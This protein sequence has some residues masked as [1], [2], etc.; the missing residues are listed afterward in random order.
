MEPQDEPGFSIR[1]YTERYAPNHEV[2]L[3]TDIGGWDYDIY[4]DYSRTSDGRGFWLFTLDPSRYFPVAGS[5][6]QVSLVVDRSYRMEHEPLRFPS[7]GDHHI[8]EDEVKFGEVPDRFLHGHDNLHVFETPVQQH[9]FRANH[10][11]DVVYDAIVV[12]SGMSGGIIADELSDRG[13]NVLLLE[14]GSLLF[15]THIYNLP[16]DWDPLKD[17]YF[18][19]GH[20]TSTDSTFEGGVK[21]NLGGGSLFWSGIIQQAEPWEFGGHWP[22]A[23]QDY[24][25]T[26][27]G[28]DRALSLMRRQLTR[29]PYEEQLV[30]EV[31]TQFPEYKV[32]RLP[33]AR[34]QPHL[35]ELRDGR[36]IQQNLIRESNGLFSTVDLLLDSMAFPGSAG[37]ANLTINTNHMV[38]H[39]EAEGGHVNAVICED[40]LANKRRRFKG[41]FVILAAGSLGSTR[42]ALASQ[43][44]DPNH[45]IGKGLTDHPN[46]S[47]R[48][49]WP[50]EDAPLGTQDHAKLMIQHAD[51]ADQNHPYNI[52]VM[53]NYQ[54][55]DRRVA[56]EDLWQQVIVQAMN[57]VSVDVQFFFPSHLNDNNQVTFDP[58]VGK[59]SVYTEA[60]EGGLRYESEVREAAVELQKVIGKG[61]Q[62]AIS[63]SL[64]YFSGAQIGHSGGTMRMGRA[65]SS[66]VDETQRVHSYDN[67]YVA[68]LSVF[69]SILAAKPSLTLA[70]LSLR[71]ADTVLGQLQRPAGNPEYRGV[72]RRA[73]SLAETSTAETGAPEL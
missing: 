41:K 3:R 32:A 7:S 54:Y 67:L 1:F 69:P 18:V 30:A 11:Q 56:D 16:G 51:A 55:W 47:V 52:E 5:T 42:I 15:P 68:D 63:R 4:G 66:V 25:T 49:E 73:A 70:A 40:L 10:N 71:L 27:G 31:T 8:Q 53:V 24:L 2:T 13:A 58:A 44:H 37:N 19:Y 34:H 6:V 26:E 38:T 61:R 50:A 21:I 59:L 72:R 35:V 39:V 45:L 17:R 14:A 48:F 46:F 9:H 57:K 23:V 20:K 29:G 64:R 33:R 36:I 60:N 22:Q 62:A 65:A 43:L 28:Y 12:G